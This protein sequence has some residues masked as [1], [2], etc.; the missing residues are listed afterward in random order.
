MITVELY[1]FTWTYKHFVMARHVLQTSD[2]VSLLL[3]SSS[4]V[5]STLDDW[6]WRVIYPTPAKQ[7]GLP[8]K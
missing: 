1:L 4:C 7:Q 3:S 8:T 6:L 2:S 5:Y